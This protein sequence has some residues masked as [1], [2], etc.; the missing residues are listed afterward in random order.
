MAD[1]FRTR[2]PLAAEDAEYY[3]RIADQS[4]LTAKIPFQ[5]EMNRL[6]VIAAAK[7]GAERTNG[8]VDQEASLRFGMKFADDMGFP[9]GTPQMG[10]A[11]E[12]LAYMNSEP[13]SR[14]VFYQAALAPELALMNASEALSGEKPLAERAARLGA[15][16]PAAFFP[17]VGYPVHQA[18][19]RMYESNPVAGLLMDYVFM[20]DVGSTA[21]GIGRAS[22]RLRYGGGVPTHLMDASGNVIRQLRNSPRLEYAR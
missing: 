13:D 20:P 18:Y 7:R 16:I 21:S 19:D 9:G 5:S 3:R 6:R 17:E 8:P 2:V 4:D 12:N 14:N 22:N 1:F 10:T 15:A 11:L